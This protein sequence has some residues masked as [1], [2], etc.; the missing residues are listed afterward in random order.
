M[1]VLVVGGGGREH[2]LVWKLAQSPDVT[3]FYAA[4]G[5]PGMEN[6]AQRVPI[7]IS[8]LEEIVAFA[9]RE[10]IDLAVVGP[11]APLASGLADRLRERGVSCFG[12]GAQGALLESSKKYARD[13]MARHGIPAPSY[14]AFSQ[15]EDAKGYVESLPEGLV[16]VKADGLAQ[17]K[18]VVVAENR[19]GALSALEEMMGA[20]RF[21]AAGKEV[22]IEECLTGEEVSLLTFVDGKTIVPMLPVQDHKRLL[23]G[24][25]GPNTGG[26]GTYAPASVFSPEV[27]AQV[28]EKI[29][30]PLGEA[31]GSGEIDYRGCLYVG[32]MLT[33]DGPKVIE[34][35]VRFGDPETQ[36]LMPLL[37]SDLFRILYACAKGNLQDAFPDGEIEWRN[38]SAVCWNNGSAVCVVMASQGYPG[39]YPSGHPISGALKEEVKEEDTSLPAEIARNSWV[40]HAGTAKGPQ[41]LVTAG[42]RVLSVTALGETLEE[43]LA[44]AYARA[45]AIHFE[46]STF[47]R[48][49]AHREL[50]RRKGQS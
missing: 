44:R 33:P 41:G 50:A 21:G 48:D 40:F 5:N 46:G 17:G 13:F 39:D 31:L 29:L 22:L 24:D 43:A 1:K 32:L 42:G 18:G 2:A 4:P 9:R 26:M 25:K 30:C 45:D 49:I 47:R 6:A 8:D 34:F 11:E 16:V 7:E 20:G 27:A 28:R 10:N 35:N 19:A 15:L 36:V 12:P 3:K 23:E 38:G 37:K 14:R